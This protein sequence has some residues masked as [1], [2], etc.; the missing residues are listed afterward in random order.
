MV[1]IADIAFVLDIKNVPA[2]LY[3]LRRI[4]EKL[5]KLEEWF[6]YQNR[7]KLFSSSILIAFDG[8]RVQYPDAKNTTLTDFSEDDVVVR[9]ID[10][11][12]T[13]I[14]LNG[15][16]SLDTNYMYGLKRLIQIFE[17]LCQSI[18]SE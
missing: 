11:P 16:Q 7:V 17:C 15:T 9:M 18:G 14:D 3:I 12:H 8:Q 2:R 5:K 6:S 4:I 13:Y 1:L 10:F